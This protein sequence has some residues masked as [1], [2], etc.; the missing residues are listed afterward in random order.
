MTTKT[1]LV[2]GLM[3]GLGLATWATGLW[4]ADLPQILEKDRQGTAASVSAAGE[5]ERLQAK[6]DDLQAERQAAERENRMLEHYRNKLQGQ[7]VR[8]EEAT[9]TLEAER[10]DLRNV[11]IHIYPLMEEMHQTIK[12][13]VE[14]DKP[15]L[16][17]ERSA[18]LARLDTLMVDPT[19]TD[20]QKMD[21]L[22]DA[23]QVEVSYGYTVGAESGTLE[24]GELV[25]FLRIGRL[26][27]YAINEA[28]G[29]AYTWNAEKKVWETLDGDWA[30]ALS[31]AVKVAAGL[32]PPDVMLMP[33]VLVAQTPLA[34]IEMKSA[35]KKTEASHE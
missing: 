29:T 2:T 13:F 12:A 16:K 8:I 25:D 7:L 3:A 10:E 5:V 27:W 4:A 28:K 33:A 19:L 34:P 15:F 24:N 23:Y 30:E 11:R 17:G 9:K 35:E 32:T 21:A 18:R 22:L 31:D 6:T 20:A 14:A 26:G 1:K